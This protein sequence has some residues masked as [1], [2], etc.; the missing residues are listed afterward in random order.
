MDQSLDDYISS[1]KHQQGG[2]RRYN[3]YYVGQ[4]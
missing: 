1:K 2:G 3:T 4:P